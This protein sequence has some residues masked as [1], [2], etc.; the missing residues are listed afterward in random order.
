MSSRSLTLT[1]D[2]VGTTH[3]WRATLRSEPCIQPLSSLLVNT[4]CSHHCSLATT[5]TFSFTASHFHYAANTLNTH[6]T[7]THILV[8]FTS[9]YCSHVFT[10]SLCFREINKNKC[11][12]GKYVVINQY[13]RC[14][15][16]VTT[17]HLT[18]V[19]LAVQV[20]FNFT[21]LEI[22]DD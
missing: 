13:K 16:F 14:S 17:I 8:I 12:S 20:T 2:I 22:N 10:I 9:C 11:C 1:L 4:P 18:L 7:I 3:V 5:P 19:G 15:Y 6:P 21:L